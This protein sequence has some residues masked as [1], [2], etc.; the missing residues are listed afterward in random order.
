MDFNKFIE[1]AIEKYSKY[2]INKV[3][4]FVWHGTDG[5]TYCWIYLLEH[6]IG[7]NE[8]THVISKWKMPLEEEKLFNWFD[9]IL[10]KK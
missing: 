4:F 8:L 5:D 10:I 3:Q 1:K 2:G 6:R 7:E 9:N